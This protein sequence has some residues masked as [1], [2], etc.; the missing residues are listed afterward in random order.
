MYPEY[1][2]EGGDPNIYRGM[3]S[4]RFDD[5][6]VLELFLSRGADP[7]FKME[8]FVTPLVG[9]VRNERSQPWKVKMLLDHG[10]DIHMLDEHQ[11]NA[12]HRMM[13]TRLFFKEKL[14]ILVQHRANINALDYLGRTPF[15]ILIQVTNHNNTI[16]EMLKYRPHFH[17]H[18]NLKQYPEALHMLI[19]RRWVVIKCFVKFLGLQQRAVVTANHPLRKLARGEFTI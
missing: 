14:E 16:R 18:G 19:R 9:A 12:I 1:L 17:Y 4:L 15:D 7:N 5:R 3:P 2:D 8:G 11:G 13:V 6:E 10:A